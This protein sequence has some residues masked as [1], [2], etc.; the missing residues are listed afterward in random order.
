MS[1]RKIAQRVTV[2]VAQEAPKV[3]GRAIT[4]FSRWLN[5]AV[6]QNLRGLEGRWE[7]TVTLSHRNQ[8][9]GSLQIRKSR[10]GKVVVQATFNSCE[11]IYLAEV[12][13]FNVSEFRAK[14]FKSVHDQV[15][16]PEL[17]A[18]VQRWCEIDRKSDG[19]I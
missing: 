2:A 11:V 12:K 18:T 3:S 6:T 4:R 1:G 8:P 19:L 7:H 5:L 10:N 9:L 13:N 15:A 16:R 17:A 14:E